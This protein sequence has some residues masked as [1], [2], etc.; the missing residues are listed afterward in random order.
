MRII[1]L[2]ALLFIA[3]PSQAQ[4]LFSEDFQDGDANGWTAG[5]KGE[6]QVTNYQGNYSLRLTR[7]A[8]AA[9]GLNVAGPEEL[10]ISVAFAAADLEKSDACRAEASND[11]GATWQILHEI[12]DGQDDSYSLYTGSKRVKA[13][14]TGPLFVRLSAD[15]NGKNDTCW[16]DNITIRAIASRSASAQAA[17]PRRF[18][19]AGF[20]SGTEGFK[21]PVA[22][23]AYAPALGA[24][25]AQVRFEGTLRFA[26]ETKAPGFAVHRDRFNFMIEALEG[27]TYPPDFT[28]NFVQVEDRI[29]PAKRGLI[30][31]E[32]KAWDIIVEVGRIWQEAGDGRSSRIA[33]PFALQERNANCTHNGVITFLVD[34][35]G[36]T[37]RAAYQISSETCAYFQYDMWGTA[38]TAFTP[39]ADKDAVSLRTAYKQ[40]RAARMPTKPFA[41]LTSDHPGLD[42]TAFAAPEDISPEHLTSFGLIIDGTHYRGGCKTRQGPYPMCEEMALPSYSTSKSVFAGLALMRLEALYPGAFDA[43]ISD[44]VPECSGTGW[45]G[46]TFGHALDMATGRY[47]KLGGEADENA[48]VRD[49]FFLTP[50]HREKIRRACSIYPRKSTPGK[51]WVYHTTDHYVLGAAMQAFLKAQRGQTADIYDTLLVEPVWTA[52]GLSPVAAQTRRTR[53]TVNQPYVGWGLTYLPDDLAKL[54]DFFAVKSGVVDGQALIDTSALAAAMQEAPSD[55]GLPAPGKGVRYNNG[56][57][58]IDA[59]RFAGCDTPLWIPFMSGFGGISVVMMPNDVTYYYVSDNYEFAWARAVTAVNAHRPMC[60]Q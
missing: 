57:W 23:A 15:A 4:T 55:P 26:P 39:G 1:T 51:T 36:A 16:A 6:V 13:P 14:K 21:A 41:A 44:Y 22:M 53:D 40:E 20:L 12:R 38:A 18:L 19:T 27:L 47:N 45:N 31:T 35:D 7:S 9:I 25:A 50:G 60:G 42:L 33:L 58:A 34:A 17:R 49:G 37:S 52:I 46:I 59:A 24:S 29:V 56:V 30:R 10:A 2:L 32:N 28:L 3:Q 54:A 8:F 5:G 43:L 48:A 11:G